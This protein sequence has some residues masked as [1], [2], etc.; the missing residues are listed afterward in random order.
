[1]V[2]GAVIYKYQ[3]AKV[4]ELGG[5]YKKMPLVS[6]ISVIA[7]L[8][9]SAFPMFSGFVTKSMIISS[10]LNENMIILSSILILGSAAVVK[11]MK[12]PLTAFFIKNNNTE[13]SKNLTENETK[14][15]FCMTLAMSISAILCIFIGCIIIEYI[16]ILMYF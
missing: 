3:T 15:P 16:S 4:T 12:V 10:A 11:Y 7:M 2:V 8:S 1:M 6:V 9:I 14:I 13:I 5:I